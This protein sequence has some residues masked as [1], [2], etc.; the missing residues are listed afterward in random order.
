MNEQTP[1][2]DLPELSNERVAHI[3]QAVF[4]EIA[5]ERRK[6][7][8]AATAAAAVR[9]KTRRRRWLTGLS[10]AAAF[11]AGVLITP[12]ILGV[13]NS[14]STFSVQSVNSAGSGQREPLY[15]SATLES[16]DMAGAQPLTIEQQV[17]DGQ[18]VGESDSVATG[19]EIIATASA[20]VRVDSIADAAAEVATLAEEHGGYVE[21][22]NIA[23]EMSADD[24]SMPEL[25][26]SGY[27]WI[28]VRVP[29]ADLASVIDELKS[30]GEVLSSSISKQDVT[31]AMIDLRARADASRASVDRLTD[32][33]KQSGTVSELIEAEV[34]LTDRQAQ[35]ESYEQQLASMKD[36]VA[37]SSLQVEL[38]RATKA[39]PADPAGFGEGL[40]AGWNGL[41]VTVNALVI[42]VG[43]LLPWLGV[44][45]V[46]LVAVWL[47]R[48]TRRRRHVES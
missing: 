9:R 28:S 4:A 13:T 34:A 16:A 1:P 7:P 24:T 12:Q 42:T 14:T 32:L 22:T 11:V 44:A 35:L 25:P 36:Q 41:I 40:L 39:A 6:A 8:T 15:G 47:I 18:Q 19:R 20:S 38:T 5:A 29:S 26:N 46:V 45:A 27:G 37:M 48:R 33:M 17:G 31:S 21:S 2:I 30:S 3:E 10:V 43:F 23:R